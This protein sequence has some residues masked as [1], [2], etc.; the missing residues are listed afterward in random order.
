MNLNSLGHCISVHQ[1][2]ISAAAGLEPGTPR[3]LSQP[4]YQWAILAPHIGWAITSK[5]LSNKISKT[6]YKY[7]RSWGFILVLHNLKH[8]LHN[9][10]FW[11]KCMLCH[12][13]TYNINVSYRELI[14]AWPIAPDI[15]I[16][17]K[18]TDCSRY[19]NTAKKIDC[20]RYTNTAKRDWLLQIYQYG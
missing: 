6:Y 10:R 18:E 7:A 2:K 3:L 11:I 14:S 1:G 15:P 12:S 9:L 16:R 20:S 8:R 19:T 4:R 13:N 5:V 17:L